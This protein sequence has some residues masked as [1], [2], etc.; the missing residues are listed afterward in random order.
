MTI[1]F[2]IG[3]ISDG[4]VYAAQTKVSR[5]YVFCAAN[6][7]RGATCGFLLGVALVNGGFSP[8]MFWFCGLL[9][10]LATPLTMLLMEPCILYSGSEYIS[11]KV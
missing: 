6:L 4:M 9:D 2:T 11:L 3:S 7:L 1:L 10:V 5:L 8:F